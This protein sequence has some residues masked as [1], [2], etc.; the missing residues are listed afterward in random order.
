MNSDEQVRQAQ[1]N[2]RT[3][4]DLK[5]KLEI[6]T[7]HVESRKEALEE[8]IEENLNEAIRNARDCL[9]RVQENIK[10]KLEGIIRERLDVLKTKMD[11]FTE[12]GLD[13]LHKEIEKQTPILTQ[14]ILEEVDGLVASKLMAA[15]NEL[16]H[17]IDQKIQAE[18]KKVLSGDKI[19]MEEKY[20]KLSRVSFVALGF[21]LIALALIL[22]ENL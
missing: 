11:R 3:I 6:L 1:A 15:R 8:E 10:P 16:S 5:E 14:K 17:S 22:L 7:E 4:T 9:E 2:F 20:A 13:A 18:V 21:S 19:E 12:E